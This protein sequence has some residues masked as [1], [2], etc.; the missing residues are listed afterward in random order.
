MGSVSEKKG[1]VGKQAEHIL[2]RRQAAENHKYIS[3]DI[4]RCNN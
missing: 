3:N 2:C 4:N 1:V